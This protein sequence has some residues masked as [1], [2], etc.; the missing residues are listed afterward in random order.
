MKKSVLAMLVLILV[1]GAFFRFYRITEV[2]LG[3]YPDEAMNGNNAVEALA[4]HD[5]K[6]FYPEN[7]GREGL[8]I[9]LQAIALGALGAH[10]WV[11]RAVSAVFGSLTVFGLYL[12]ARELFRK[13][14]GEYLAL[15]SS[16]FLATSYWHV[17]FSRIGFRAILVPFFTV[18]GLYFLLKGLRQRTIWDLT[19][20]GIFVGLGFHTYIAFRFMPFVLIVPLAWFLWRAYGRS[21]PSGSST[22]WDEEIPDTAGYSERRFLVQRVSCTLCA[23]VLFLFVTLVVALPIGVHFLTHPQDFFGRSGQVSVLASASPV[24]ELVKSTGLTIGML[25]VHGDCNWRHN[26]NCEPALHPFVAILFLIGMGAGIRSLFSRRGVG[27]ERRLSYAILF[28]LLLFFSLP[29]IL[30]DEGLPHALRSIGMIPPVMILAGIGAWSTLQLPL[31]WLRKQVIRWP[32]YRLQIERIGREVVILFVFLLLLISLV[33]YDK[34]FLRWAE[35][36]E[37]YYSFATDSWHLGEYLA[38]LPAGQRKYV[39]VNE[40]GTDV[41]GIPMPAQTIMFATGTFTVGGQRAKNT[42]YLL[43]NQLTSALPAP[44]VIA[45]LNSDDRALIHAAE[46]LFPD[47][48]IQ[49]PG[50]FVVLKK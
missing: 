36:R 42:T 8:F 39:V 28:A 15:L 9:N 32:R 1:L 46:K 38:G 27:R 35:N 23:V 2:P 40:G 10:P 44:E 6:V 5:F 7:N 33:T 30:T 3:L 11:L 12:L 18:F 49:V 34:Y 47:L 24:R 16:F 48:R 41:R 19:F 31:N 26:Y 45:F 20:A 43:P 17:N 13:K 22:P 4:T 37:T 50:D 29:A 21:Q 25:F 14:G